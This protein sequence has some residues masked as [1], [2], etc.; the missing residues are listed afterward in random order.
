VADVTSQFIDSVA[1]CDLYVS[2]VAEFRL[3]PI[4]LRFQ[5]PDRI[6]TPTTAILVSWGQL[7]TWHTNWASMLARSSP[8]ARLYF[9]KGENFISI[10]L[11]MMHV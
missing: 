11:S 10:V 6:I 3:E 2:P 1:I 9:S 5:I 8:R 4:H 7:M